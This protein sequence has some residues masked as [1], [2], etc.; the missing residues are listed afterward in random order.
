MSCVLR[1]TDRQQ[2]KEIIN[3]THVAVTNIYAR[4]NDIWTNPEIYRSVS[5]RH[6]KYNIFR[7]LTE[8]MRDVTATT[9]IPRFLDA[10]SDD[11]RN[12]IYLEHC[13]GL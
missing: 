12:I 2:D 7:V 9:Q 10:C 3:T 1:S 13:P 5:A 6:E 4:S 11:M 8:G